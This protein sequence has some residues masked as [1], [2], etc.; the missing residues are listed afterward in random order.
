MNIF[1]LDNDP[2][3]AAQLQCD[4]HVVKMITESAQMLCT[5]H[6]ILDGDITIRDSNSG[7]RKVKY[8]VLNDKREQNYYKA[9]HMNHPCTV[10]TMK[11]TDNYNW[12]YRHFIALCDEYT[13]RYNKVHKCDRLFHGVLDRPPNNIRSGGLT[14]FALAMGSNPECI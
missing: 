8:W 2:I 5:A 10:W 7:K 9:V 4:K 11:S 1:V 14:K 3:E 13:Y 12:H 6:R